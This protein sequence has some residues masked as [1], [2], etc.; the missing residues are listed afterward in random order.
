MPNVRIVNGL[1]GFQVISDTAAYSGKWD[2]LD[3]LTDTKFHTLSGSPAIGAANTTLGSAMT[4]TA[5]SKVYGQFT[6]IQLHSGSIAAYRR[7]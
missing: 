1:Y 5:G 2:V 4:W 7:S 3:I 6:G